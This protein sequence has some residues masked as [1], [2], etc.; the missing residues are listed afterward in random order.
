[1]LRWSHI[2]Q[3]AWCLAFLWF[4]FSPGV[5]VD[6]GHEPTQILYVVAVGSQGSSGRKPPLLLLIVQV[7]QQ[8]LGAVTEVVE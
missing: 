1:M 6:A 4:L 7:C 3:E 2:S 8:M 5:P